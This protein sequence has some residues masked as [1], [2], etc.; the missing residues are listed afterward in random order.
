MDETDSNSQNVFLGNYSWSER[1]AEVPSRYKDSLL[2]YGG[3]LFWM[4]VQN[5]KI[6]S[7]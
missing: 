4:E 3:K 5:I 2:Y 6:F 7:L 1:T